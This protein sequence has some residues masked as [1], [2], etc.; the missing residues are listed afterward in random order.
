M[1]FTKSKYRARI[2]CIVENGRDFVVPA[3]RLL[4]A[5]HPFA[6]AGREIPLLAG[7]HFSRK[8]D[9][10]RRC[11]T[12]FGLRPGFKRGRVCAIATSVLLQ[13]GFQAS[14]AHSRLASVILARQLL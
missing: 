8:I 2:G 14:Q 3:P 7:S 11:A 6:V 5:C 13:R 4:L 12:P 1:R 9:C 10:R